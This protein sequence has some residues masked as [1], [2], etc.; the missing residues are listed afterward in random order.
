VVL[1]DLDSELHGLP[2]GFSASVLGE[3]KNVSASLL[4]SAGLRNSLQPKI[5]ELICVAIKY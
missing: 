3:V 5:A 1:A 2:L 4:S